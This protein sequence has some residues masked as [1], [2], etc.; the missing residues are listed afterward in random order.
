MQYSMHSRHTCP[1]QPTSTQTSGQVRRT[2]GTPANLSYILHIY[3]HTLTCTVYL[4][5]YLDESLSIVLI[6][7]MSLT[8][9]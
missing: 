2:I 6:G 1:S 4:I 3:T 8:I 7:V 9:M 5:G